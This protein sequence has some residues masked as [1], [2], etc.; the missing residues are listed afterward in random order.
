MSEMPAVRLPLI[1]ILIPS[2][3]LVTVS[4]ILGKNICFF[5]DILLDSSSTN[6]ASFADSQSTY[7]IVPF[8]CMIMFHFYCCC[9]LANKAV[10]VDNS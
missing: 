4:G 9:E 1:Q 7:L 5:Y 8:F 10:V 2:L 3:A 6:T